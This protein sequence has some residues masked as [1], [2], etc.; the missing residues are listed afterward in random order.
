MTQGKETII[1]QTTDKINQTNLENAASTL[2]FNQANDRQNACHHQQ[3]HY[4]FL[5]H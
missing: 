3:P 5:A 1:N 2:P 4:H